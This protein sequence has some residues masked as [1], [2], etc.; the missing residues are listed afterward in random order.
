MVTLAVIALATLLASLTDW[1]F[2]DVLVHRRYAASAQLW[3]PRG[4]TARI[5]ISQVIGTLATAAVVLL[6]QAGV[7]PFLVALLVWLAGPLAVT[8]Q[9]LQWMNLPPAIAASYAA[10]WAARLFIAALLVRLLG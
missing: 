6:C 1:L 3:R 5:L 10:G 7:A 4:G 8:L 9:N 2:M